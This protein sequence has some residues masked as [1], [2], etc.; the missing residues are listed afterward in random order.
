MKI[1]IFSQYYYPEPFKINEICEELVK[2]GNELTVLTGLPNY[3]EGEIYKDYATFNCKKYEKIN[4]VNILRVPLRPRKKGSLNLI[5]NYLSYVYQGIK[6]IKDLNKHYDVVLVYQLSPVLMA[7]PA[8]KFC[9]KNNIPLCIYCLDLWPESIK[10]IGLTESNIMYKILKFVSKKIYK[11]CDILCVSSPSF[12]EYFHKLFGFDKDKI[13]F[14]PQ[15]GESEYLDIKERQLIDKI[16]ITYAGNIGKAQE[17]D[18]LFQAV[19]RVREE[20]RV[21]VI[22]KLIGSGSSLENL[23]NCVKK[24]KFENFIYFTGRVSKEELKEYYQDSDILFV[25]LKNDTLLGNTIPTKL[26]TYMSVGRPIL[27][28]LD[29][30]AKDIIEKSNCGLIS[31]P[32]NIDGCVQNILKLVE[33][34]QMYCDNSREYYLKNFTLEKVSEEFNTLLKQMKEEY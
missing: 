5:F 11:S 22:V 20:H 2:N 4:G 34:Y 12:K 30:D 8:I 18:T 10:T 14:I 13:K 32:N 23:K 19:R 6:K 21:D 1:L 31:N 33:D 24:H 25:S 27:A 3:P 15:H 26:Q 28:I 16:T 7:I 29:G 9:R 17:F